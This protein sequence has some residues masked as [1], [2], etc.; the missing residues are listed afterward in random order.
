MEVHIGQCFGQILQCLLV[1]ALFVQ[2]RSHRTVTARYL[3][4]IAILLEQSQRIGRKRHDQFLPWQI[5]L[6]DDTHH[7]RPMFQQCTIVLFG[8]QHLGHSLRCICFKV[9]IVLLVADSET[10]Q[11]IVELADQ[12]LFPCRSL[13]HSTRASHVVIIQPLRRVVF[14]CFDRNGINGLHG[15][16]LLLEIVIIDRRCDVEFGASIVIPIAQTGILQNLSIFINQ[17]HP[18][19]GPVAVIIEL[20]IHGGTLADFHHPHIRHQT[21]QFIACLIVHLPEQ[22]VRP[23]K[24]HPDEGAESQVIQRFGLRR[25][26]SARQGQC[27]FSQLLGQFQVLIAHI[28]GL[29]VQRIRHQTIHT[30]AP[31][32]TSKEKQ[33]ASQYPYET[34]Q[35][36]HLL[37][38]NKKKKAIHCTDGF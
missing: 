31:S 3:V 33:E 32:S 19:Q 29:A 35:Q 1:P 14:Q 18:F 17:F 20:F 37:Q 9:H 25:M 6:I 11:Q 10:L 4:P 24:I 38:V 7:P 23:F 12:H 27:L 5:L 26:G 22:A 16:C 30:P 36:I 34:Q 13:I 2:T 8:L 15:L 21:F 28:I